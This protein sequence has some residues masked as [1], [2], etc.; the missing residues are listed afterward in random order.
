MTT[1]PE[2][3]RGSYSGPTRVSLVDLQQAGKIINTIK[4]LNH[5]GDDTLDI[6]YYIEKG[7]YYHMEGVFP[8]ARRARVLP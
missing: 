8:R 3:T 6:P 5:E 2:Y 4:I 1:C 7:F